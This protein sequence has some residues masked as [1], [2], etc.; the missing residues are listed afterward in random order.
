MFDVNKLTLD[1]NKT[2]DNVISL[3][4]RTLRNEVILRKEVLQRVNKAKLLGVIVDQ[5]LNWKDH[6]SIISPKNRLIYLIRNNLDINFI[7]LIYYSLIHPYLT[8]CVNV[9]SSTYQTNLMILCTAQ[10]RPH[11]LRLHSN[12]ILWIL[13]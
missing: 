4:I 6:I 7:G 13:S 11:N 9:W 3:K 12:G 8:C 2:N 1:V 5:H 10:M